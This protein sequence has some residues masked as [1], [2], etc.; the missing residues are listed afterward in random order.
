M[1]YIIFQKKQTGAISLLHRYKKFKYLSVI[2]QTYV[3][4]TR[5]ILFYGT[6]I[7]KLQ[8]LA[9]KIKLNSFNI[10]QKKDNFYCLTGLD[11]VNQYY[12]FNDVRLIQ[13]VEYMHLNRINIINKI[14]KAS[15]IVLFHHGLDINKFNEGD[16]QKFLID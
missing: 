8:R 5:S 9:T 1:N 14:S 3:S 7:N 13:C 16:Y 15:I 2:N 4:N 12:A 10:W 6:N 11:K